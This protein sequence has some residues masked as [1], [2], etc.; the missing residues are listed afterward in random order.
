MAHL[1]TD[2]RGRPVPGVNRWGPED[3]ARL[4]V[5]HDRLVGGLAIFD[6]DEAETVPD[7]T[8]QNMGRQREAILAGLCQV[9]WRP[10]PWSRR[11][12]VYAD[13]AVSVVNVPGLGNCVVITEPWLDEE[14]AEFALRT[15]P[16]LIRRARSERLALVPIR[17]ARDVEVVV[18]TGWVDGPLE[19]QTKAEPPAMWAKI[20]VLTAG[21]TG[22]GSG[23]GHRRVM[24]R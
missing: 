3:A 11:F 15:C 1:R 20:V 6:D 8:A 4:A 12:L 5:R 2:R 18:S 16:A 17:S 24:F 22:D 13:L 21:S 23:A 7:F 10:V 14:C 9:C 19:E